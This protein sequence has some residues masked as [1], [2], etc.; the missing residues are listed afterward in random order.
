MQPREVRVPVHPCFLLQVVTRKAGH[1]LVRSSK[2]RPWTCV[3]S[4]G[5]MNF[6]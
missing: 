2:Q 6:E 5:M 4:C 3:P 1:A